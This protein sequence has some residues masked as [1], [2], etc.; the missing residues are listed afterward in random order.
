MGQI[1][2]PL[3]SVVLVLAQLSC[4]SARCRSNSWG[5]SAIA[6][7]S[8]D[9]YRVVS[10]AHNRAVSTDFG[11]PERFGSAYA[12]FRAEVGDA[13]DGVEEAVGRTW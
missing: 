1:S 4:G 10:T 7:P 3:T 2:I 8:E 5:A 13:G 6:R 11:D 9:R 12:C